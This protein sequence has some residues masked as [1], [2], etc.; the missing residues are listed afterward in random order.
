MKLSVSFN[1]PVNPYY[2]AFSVGLKVAIDSITGM[3]KY[4]DVVP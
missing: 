1:H 3:L 2:I 4:V